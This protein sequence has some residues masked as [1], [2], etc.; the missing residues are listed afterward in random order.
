MF[1]GSNVPLNRWFYAIHQ[2]V[3]HKKGISSLQLSRDISVTQKTAWFMLHRIRVNLREVKRILFDGVVQMDETYVG[4][5]NKGRFKNNRG[6]ST[7]QKVPVVGVLT[8]SRVYVVTVSDV[9]Q[10]TLH[11]IV[12]GL[13]KPGSTLVTDELS[14]YNGL[15]NEYVHER[16]KHRIRQYVNERGFHTNSIEGFWSH[17]KRGTKGTYHWVSRKYLQHYCN[18]FAYRYNT[19]NEGDLE[20]FMQFLLRADIRVKY[21][22]LGWNAVKS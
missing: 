11:T 3:T 1:E 4:G 2:F 15:S 20:A 10:R 7:K 18:E 14:S 19:R 9:N 5:R 21:S 13:I 6:R 16:V 17:L 8:K 12:Q 22:D